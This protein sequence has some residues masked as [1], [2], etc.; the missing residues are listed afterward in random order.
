MTM[1]EVV[2]REGGETRTVRQQA[3][4]KDWVRAFVGANP[5]LSGAEIVSVTPA[6]R[7]PW[8]ATGP[9]FPGVI[10]PVRPDNQARLVLLK[11]DEPWVGYG[12]QASYDMTTPRIINGVRVRVRKGPGKKWV[13]MACA[14][15]N[16]GLCAIHGEPRKREVAGCSC[17]HKSH[18]PRRRATNGPS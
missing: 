2:I 7:A 6:G 11:L 1:Y 8:R 16:H 18:R 4:S 14:T 17:A 9:R 3:Y 5:H 12:T 10:R 13:T 15:G